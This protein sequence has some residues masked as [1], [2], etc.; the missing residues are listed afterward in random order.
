MPNHVLQDDDLMLPQAGVGF[1]DV[2]TGHPGTHSHKFK[3]ATFVTWSSV[4]Y[5]RLTDHM[6]RASASIGYSSTSLI[7]GAK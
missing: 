4:F 5:K 1:V 7:V 3:S 6:E 2:G